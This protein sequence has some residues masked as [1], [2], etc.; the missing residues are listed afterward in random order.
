MATNPTTTVTQENVIAYIKQ[1]KLERDSYMKSLVTLRKQLEITDNKLFTED[2]LAKLIADS[3]AAI[4]AKD[5]QIAALNLRLTNIQ[6]TIPG[7]GGT[8]ITPDF[9]GRPNWDLDKWTTVFEDNFPVLAPEGGAF[10]KTYSKWSAY[11]NHYLTTNRKGYYEPN[12]LSVVDTPEGQ[13]VLQC[14]LVP[15]SYNSS[16]R[17]SGTAACPRFGSQ[18]DGR[19]LNERLSLRIRVTKFADNWH[20]ANLGWPLKDSDWPEKG[21]D[22]IW[23][24]SLT[25]GSKV[26]GYLHVQ[27]GGS[28]GERQV[29]LS[30]DIT[31]DDWFVVTRERFAGKSYKWFVN[32]KQYGETVTKDVPNDFFRW[33]LQLEP[34]VG[35]SSPQA[36]AIVQYDWMVIEVPA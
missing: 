19:T 10:L 18:G 20:A 26:G 32:G 3:K 9:P 25:R 5:T 34:Q 7:A 14:R 11:P 23:E 28:N 16:H 17:P 33:V 31:I 36:E 13:R 2:V 4:A 1:L 15:G 22:D 24:G 30:S 29:S 21:E 35:G 6:N 12:N 8:I 27:N